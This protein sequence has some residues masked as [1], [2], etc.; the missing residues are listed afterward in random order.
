M[1]I[2]IHNGGG[3]FTSR[4]IKYCNTQGIDYKLVNAYDF[5]IMKQLDD[6]DAFMWHCS[7]INYKDAL[8]AK[9]L[10][11]SVEASGKKVFPNSQS[12]WHFDDKVGQKYLLEAI[13]APLVSSYVFFLGKM[14]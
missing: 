5:D 6:C 9:Q 3:S 12:V 2:A 14:L 10:L 1:K 13:G 8:F 7:H 4:W 11:Y